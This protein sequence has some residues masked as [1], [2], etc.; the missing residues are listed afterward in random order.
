M[1]RYGVGLRPAPTPYRH[2]L[3]MVFSHS[4]PHSHTW[5]V[6]SACGPLLT[7]STVK[8][9]LFIPPLPSLTLS[10][11]CVKPAPISRPPSPEPVLTPTLLRPM[12][13]SPRR[14]ARTISRPP[15]QASARTHLS[16]SCH[17]TAL[18]APW[19]RAAR[20][21]ESG[22]PSRPIGGEDA[23]ELKGGLET[24]LTGVP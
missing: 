9:S 21:V 5:L 16:H 6:V 1:G 14:Q 22:Q 3:P 2:G 13:S 10:H 20:A 12:P 8:V 23:R 19:L 7:T 15:S 17:R 24:R 4:F 11:L 18:G